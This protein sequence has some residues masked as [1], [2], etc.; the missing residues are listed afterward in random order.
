VPNLTVAVPKDIK[1]F[2]KM[3]EFSV[4]FNAP[5]AIRYPRECKKVFAK[6][7]EIVLGK[8]EKLVDGDS[9]FAIIACGERALTVGMK[10][11][12]ELSESGIKISV[13]N[14]RFVKPLDT[15]MLDGLSE[16]FLIT[17][18]DNML[19]GGLGALIDT[20]FSGRSK[21][22]KNFAYEDKFIPHGGVDELMADFG[23]SA[24]A[25]SE[26]IKSNADR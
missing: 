19:L 16:K 25:V 3:L 17:I 14:A 4:N 5:L 7:S 11:A 15:E 10:V 6:Q 26:Y 20:Y 9:D 13:I 21:I 22:I 24:K 2:E 8:W 23:V 12:E 18:E 1:E